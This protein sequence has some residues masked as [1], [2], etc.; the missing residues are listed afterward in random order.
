MRRS[1][2]V[3]EKVVLERTA[4]YNARGRE[5][6]VAQDRLRVVELFPEIANL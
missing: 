3:V 4:I 5:V 1:V 6:Q 2:A